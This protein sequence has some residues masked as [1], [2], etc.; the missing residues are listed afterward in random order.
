MKFRIPSFTLMGI[1]REAEEGRIRRCGYDYQLR[2]HIEKDHLKVEQ[3]LFNQINALNEKIRLKDE[4]IKK[5]KE[6]NYEK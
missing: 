1:L 4:E 2:E 6:K 5:L 3:T